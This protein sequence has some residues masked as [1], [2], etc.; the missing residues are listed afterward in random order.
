VSMQLGDEQFVDAHC[1]TS[2]RSIL[3]ARH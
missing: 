3:T 1:D 2:Q